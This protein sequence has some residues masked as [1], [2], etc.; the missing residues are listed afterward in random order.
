VIRETTTVALRVEELCCADEIALVERAVRD[1]PGLDTLQVNLLAKR[2]TVRY[3]ARRLSEAGIVAALGR[4]GLRATREGAPAP[5]ASVWAARSPLILLVES[6]VAIGLGAGL[7]L[8]GGPRPVAIACYLVGMISAG[9]PIAWRG[10][11]AAWHRSL[12]MNFLMTVATVGAVA[13]G[14]WF[15]GATVIWLFALAEFL[16]SYSLGRARRAIQALMELAP[17]EATVRR[18]G[19]EERVPVSDVNVGEVILVRPGTKIPLDGRV[20]GGA[21]WVNQA[22]IT[23]E[24]MPVEKGPG[25]IVYAG[26]L[27]ERGSLEVEVTHRPQDTT[28]AR[29]IHL[30]EEAQAQRAPAQRFVERFARVYTPLVMGAAILVAILPPLLG[31]PFAPWFYRALV[32]LVI[33]CPCALVISTPV[34]IVSGLAA[35]ARR[36]VL[37]KGG[38]CLEALGSLRAVA[39]DKTGTL[40][41]GGPHVTDVLPL[42]GATPEEILATASAVEARSEHPLAEAVRRRAQ[43]TGARPPGVEGFEALPGR[44]ARGRVNG[45]AVH[46]GSHRLIEDLGVCGP[47]VEAH[48]TRLEDEGKTVVFVA[49]QAGVIGL[50]AVADQTRRTA[51]EAVE[52]LRRLG[53]DRLIMLTGDNA[54]TAEAVRSRLGLSACRAELLPDAKVEAVRELAR[55]GGPV[56]MVGDGVNDAPALAAATVGIAIGAAATDVALETADVALMTDDL[57][58]LAEAIALSRRV[59]QVIVA[60]IVVSLVTKAAFLALAV[61]G[62]ATLW[63]AILA[64]M[65][66]SLAVIANALR[67]LRARARAPAQ[68]EPS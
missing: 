37:I 29:I 66:T 39:F 43:E 27:N 68:E 46:V 51:A 32:M 44:G 58:K 61:A 5:P 18:N 62:L 28:L 48:A 41:V 63:M 4:A 52:A 23:G 24:S 25:E 26:T 31:A 65:G 19:R 9:Y 60:N 50:I 64:D 49:S 2:L 45:M 40:T 55:Q 59:R 67:L 10:L 17:P 8:G 47:E 7:S 56:A 57:T 12:D 1:L 42:D 34:S 20:I 36:G 33:A 16:E 38:T 22:P 14:D 35:A 53:I 21:S 54:R 3:D 30:V 15:E 6:G 11:R 13:I